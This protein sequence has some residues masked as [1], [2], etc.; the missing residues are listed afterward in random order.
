M[1]HTH[2]HGTLLSL[3][4][5]PVPK[6]TACNKERA[7]P[8]PNFDRRA[9]ENVFVDESNNSNAATPERHNAAACAIDGD[10]S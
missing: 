8:V 6:P 1:S 10:I 9:R 4:T 2:A 3:L 7:S 5:T